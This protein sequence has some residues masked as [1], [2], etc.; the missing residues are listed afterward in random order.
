[1][2]LTYSQLSQQHHQHQQQLLQ[3]QQQQQQQQL[4]QL[5][6]S[7]YMP[8]HCTND[9]SDNVMSGG[10]TYTVVGNTN[11]T[12]GIQHH[13][14]TTSARLSPALKRSSD[15]QELSL[16]TRKRTAM[17]AMSTSGGTHF[18][19]SSSSAHSP[20]SMSVILWI[21]IPLLVGDS[22]E[23]WVNR[24]IVVVYRAWSLVT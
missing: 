17:S 13:N 3:Q 5:H 8:Q 7:N 12:Q 11:M 15:H 14:Q 18:V 1:M 2:K 23:C 16:N 21:D 20:N 4:S 24:C 10:Q 19:P 22:V 9:S 6:D